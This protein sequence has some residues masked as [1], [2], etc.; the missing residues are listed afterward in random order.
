MSCRRVVVVIP[1]NGSKFLMVKNPDRGWEFPGGKVESG[2]CLEEAAKRE[3]M[4]E[5]GVIIE[6]I[7]KLGAEGEVTF[8]TANVKEI[9]GEHQ[10]ERAFFE[11]L[12]NDL[13]FSYEEAERY[14]A[15][16]FVKGKHES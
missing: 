7:F 15:Q 13:A 3:C 16:A 12:P 5:A 2:E 14:L 8:F 9:L 1:I 11:K 4:E 6:K 10:F